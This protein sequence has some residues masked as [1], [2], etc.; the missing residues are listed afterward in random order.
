M[1]PLA[2]GLLSTTTGCPNDLLMSLAI[3]RATVSRMPPGATGTMR[4][5]AW[6]GKAGGCANEV[7]DA[8]SAA[9]KATRRVFIT[10]GRVRIYFGGFFFAIN[11]LRSAKAAYVDTRPAVEE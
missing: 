11:S 3:I 6:V 10:A 9:A 4:V 2:P 8:R 5:T 7:S 1:L